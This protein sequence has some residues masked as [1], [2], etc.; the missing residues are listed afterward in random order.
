MRV[1]V[2]EDEH[3]VR[4]M[5]ARL[6]QEAGHEPL[7]AATVQEAESHDSEIIIADILLDGGGNGI[8]WIRSLR[9]RG[10]FRPAVI[11]SALPQ[12]NKLDLPEIVG[13][14]DKPFGPL[15]FYAALAK[16]EAIARDI[17]KICAAPAVL[18]ERAKR[19]DEATARM[20]KAIGD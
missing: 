20:M 5:V 2:L 1:L 18:L 8:D 15:D 4:R 16:A 3:S 6:V 12:D 13:W 7:E 9:E 19:L 17:A 11:M 14:L 10:D